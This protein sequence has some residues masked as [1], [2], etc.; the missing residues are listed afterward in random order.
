MGKGFKKRKGYSALRIISGQWQSRPVYFID[1]ENIRPTAERMRETLFNWLQQK[2]QGRCCLDLYAGSG[3]LGIEA[4]SRGAERCVFVDKESQNIAMIQEQLRGFA[5]EKQAIAIQG[6]ALQF[7]ENY[8]GPAFSGV[9]MD[10]PYGQG[11]FAK[12]V[13]MLER[14]N[15]LQ[16]SA[17][18]YYEQRKGAESAEAP[19]WECLKTS[20]VGQALGSLWVRNEEAR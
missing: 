5:A 9:F 16:P 14:K 13:S 10:P 15:L 17:W 7:A 12:I 2:V 11:D 3:V 8:S 4:L 1:N 6:Q 18:I 20:M 19:G